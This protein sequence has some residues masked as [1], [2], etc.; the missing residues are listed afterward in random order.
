MVTSARPAT[1]KPLP[2]TDWAIDA[3]PGASAGLQ[4]GFSTR[5]LFEHNL[6]SL[7][8]VL[9]SCKAHQAGLVLLTTTRVYSIPALPFLPLFSPPHFSTLHSG[10]RAST[11]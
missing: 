8:N 11:S 6:T 5:Q 4:S 9:E 2:A 3:N 1:W 7:V 10:L